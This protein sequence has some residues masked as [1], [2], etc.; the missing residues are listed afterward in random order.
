[1]CS[2]TGF[3][4]FLLTFMSRRISGT[5][6]GSAFRN[7]KPAIF[8]FY[9]SSLYSLVLEMWKKA[10]FVSS[11][12]SQESTPRQW[13][14]KSCMQTSGICWTKWYSSFCSLAFMFLW[15]R[16]SRSVPH[17][18]SQHFTSCFATALLLMSSRSRMYSFWMLLEKLNINLTCSCCAHYVSVSD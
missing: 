14:R 18:W 17:I 4:M 9:L 2:Q 12:A 6:L 7:I 1:M 13:I 15:R 8:F 5:S 3:K 16:W 11:S 10:K